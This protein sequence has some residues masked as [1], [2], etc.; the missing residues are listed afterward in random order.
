MPSSF[1]CTFPQRTL[2]PVPE[3][4]MENRAGT[5]PLQYDFSTAPSSLKNGHQSQFLSMSN[6]STSSNHAQ[7]H[8]SRAWFRLVLQKL[9]NQ[10]ARRRAHGWR[11][12]VYLVL[13]VVSLAASTAIIA[14]I[15]QALI[16]HRKTR[17]IRQFSGADNAW[18]RNMSLIA[19][20]ILLTVAS[21][22]VLKAATCSGIEIHHWARPYRNRFL[23]LSA[24]CS[25]LMA[26]M[27]V[28]AF[29]IAEIY[30][31][32]DNDFAAWACARSDAAFNQVIPYKAICNEEV[33]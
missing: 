2:Y 3:H 32:S 15:A 16:S 4:E 7:S 30:R 6:S 5:N 33:C 21:A 1:H 25:A 29:V 10:D 14:L 8:K 24:V 26:T 23:V 27:W 11:T 19:S 20:N 12:S 28:P 13:H 17:H 22:N 9:E 18:P 31:K